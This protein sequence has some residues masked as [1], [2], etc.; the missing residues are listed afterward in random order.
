MFLVSLLILFGI[1][2]LTV[3]W[4]GS[5]PRH[6]LSTNQIARVYISTGG[7]Q[8]RLIKHNIDNAVFISFSLGKRDIK[9]AF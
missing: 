1:A 6:G 8:N 4:V 7:R 5:E 2:C 9:I 3:V